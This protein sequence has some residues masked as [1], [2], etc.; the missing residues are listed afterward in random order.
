MSQVWTAD[1][2][3]P[4]AHMGLDPFPEAPSVFLGLH[5][6]GADAPGGRRP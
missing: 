5:T 4:G 6:I 3:P 2:Q 1:L